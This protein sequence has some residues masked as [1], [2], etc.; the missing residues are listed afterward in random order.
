MVAQPP[1]PARRQT[2]A[3]AGDD[4]SITLA[5]LASQAG[6]I[7]A[8]VGRQPWT[9]Q[10]LLPACVSGSHIAATPVAVTFFIFLALFTVLLAAEL[11]IMLRQ[12]KIGPNE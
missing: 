2:L 8:E 9:I 10:N 1:R 12:I 3:A 7:V 4:Q 6:W 11:A 5:Y